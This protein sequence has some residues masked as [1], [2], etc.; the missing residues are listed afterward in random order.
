MLMELD[1][2]IE[3]KSMSIFSCT[4]GEARKYT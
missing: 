1:S 4:A 3:H 2:E